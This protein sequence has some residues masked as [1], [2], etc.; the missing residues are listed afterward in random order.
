MPQPQPQRVMQRPPQPVRRQ[1]VARPVAPV[2]VPIQKRRKPQITIIPEDNELKA[3]FVQA[4][5]HAYSNNPAK[6]MNIF[7]K[8]MK[9]AESI[10][11]CE[12]QSKICYE[13]A[14]IYDDN[15]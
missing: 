14:K 3:L 8:A 4:K 2:Q 1:P 7:Q 15:N 12:S 11:D 6:A 10:N 9:R 5:R 13:M